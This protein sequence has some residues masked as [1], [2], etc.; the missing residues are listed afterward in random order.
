MHGCCRDK[1]CDASDC[2][3]LPAGKTCADCVHVRKCTALCG[4]EP[5]NTWCDW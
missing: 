1:A 2:M 3:T 4:A 5:T